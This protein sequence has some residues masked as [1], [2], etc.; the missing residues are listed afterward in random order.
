MGRLS[1]HVLD[2]ERGGFAGFAF[3]ERT[4]PIVAAVDGL[5]VAGGLE[6]VRAADIVVA[7]GRTPCLAERPPERCRLPQPARPKLQADERR[8]R[9]LGRP[10]GRTPPPNGFA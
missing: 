8:E 1:T 10:P 3:R 4:K 9:L 5:A 2:T 7:T 6:I